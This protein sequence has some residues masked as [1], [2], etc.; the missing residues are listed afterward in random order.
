[1]FGTLVGAGGGFVLTPV[2]LLLYPKEPPIAITA[3][4]LAVVFANALSGSVS[5]Y[6]MQRA[7]YRSGWVLAV[8]TLPGSILG[9]LADAYIPRRAFD[10]VMGALLVVVAGLLVAQPEKRLSVWLRGPFVVERSLID[11][12][13]TCYRYR[14]N[15]GLAALLSVGV[16]FLSSLLGIGGGIVHVPLLTSLFDFPAHVATATSHFVLMLMAA[17][18]TITHVVHGDFSSPSLVARTV[19][20]ALGVVVGAPAGAGL[21]RRLGG[22]LIIRLLALALA[23]AGVR[24]LL[25]GVL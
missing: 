9:V 24:L 23:L 22:R 15:L 19:L 7:D 2:L 5:Y 12:D 8:A 10:E 14:F 17:S 6:R 1:M 4:S 18:G 16:G 20:L 21:S 13:G 3:T 11:T 25:S